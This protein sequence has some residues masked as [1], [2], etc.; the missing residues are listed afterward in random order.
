MRKAV[1]I[2]SI[3]IETEITFQTVFVELFTERTD[4]RRQERTTATRPTTCRMTTDTTIVAPTTASEWDD[5]LC[6]VVVVVGCR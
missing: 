3:I 6:V 5:G 4:G 1:K 2:F